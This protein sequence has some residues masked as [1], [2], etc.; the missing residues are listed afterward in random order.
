[1]KSRFLILFL[2]LISLAVGAQQS[3]FPAK[4]SPPRLVNDFAGMLTPTEVSE[5]EQKVNRF[6]DSTSIEISIVIIGNLGDYDIADYAFQLGDLWGIGKKSKDNGVLLLIAKEN[7]KAF[8]ATGYGMGGVLP[9]MR[10]KRII[11][12]ELIPQFKRGNYYNGINFSVDAI[13]RYSANEYVADPVQQKGLK[14]GY[15]FLFILV[16]IIIIGFIN[17][18]DS[19]NNSNGNSGNGSGG[20]LGGLLGGAAMGSSYRNSGGFGGFGGGSSGGGGF[21]GFG[22]GGF[23]GGGSGGSW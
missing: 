19:G 9:D 17:R 16:A 6:N 1:M 15:V 8:I 11:E 23:G 4:P 22:G 12:S 20:F 5:L 13:I 2:F 7:R 3:D 18:K 14:P 21:G 10:C